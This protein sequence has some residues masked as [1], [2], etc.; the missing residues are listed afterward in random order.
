MVQACYRNILE[1][2]VVANI[3]Y[4]VK[5]YL[6]ITTTNKVIDKES[7]T[8]FWIG[9]AYERDCRKLKHPS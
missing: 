8:H 1:A 4:I 9:S 6:K 2:E 3:D 5:S 7:F